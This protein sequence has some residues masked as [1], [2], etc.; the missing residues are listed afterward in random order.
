[1]TPRAA[2]KPTLVREPV[3]RLLA[4]AHETR[5]CGLVRQ[6]DFEPVGRIVPID[7]ALQGRL[8]PILELGA[9]FG[10]RDGHALGAVDLGEAAGEHRL[11]LVIERA[12][13]LRFPAVPHP[14]ADGADV[15]GGED[16]EK[17][18]PLQRLH[19]GGEILDGLAVGKIARLRHRRHHQMNLDQPGDQ[20]GLGGIKP[21][22]RTQPPRDARAGQRVILDAALGDIV[23][24]Q[25]DAEH[26]AMLRLDGLDQLARQ[27]NSG[28]SPRSISLSTPMQ[29][30]RCSS[31]V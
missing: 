15:G 28:L 16:G 23:Q 1:M 18:Q 14:G 19:D 12:Q 22:P 20:F 11:G 13:Q 6:I 8:R 31:T 5:V 26:G 10:L 24:E 17:L 21:E 4:G 30:I 9:E 7:I 29:R 3:A 2:S 25:R 27:A